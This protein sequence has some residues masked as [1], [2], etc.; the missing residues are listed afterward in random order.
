MDIPS[1]V[2]GRMSEYVGADGKWIE[3]M[4]KISV[5]SLANSLIFLK[6][7]QILGL[8]KKEKYFKSSSRE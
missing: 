3:V 4:E 1:M 2:T 7:K 5:N 8:G 6:R